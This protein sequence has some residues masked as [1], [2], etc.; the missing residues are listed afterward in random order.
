M[1]GTPTEVEDLTGSDKGGATDAQV[2]PGTHT[3]DETRKRKDSDRKKKGWSEVAGTKLIEPES[4][5]SVSTVMPNRTSPRKSS[6]EKS[7]GTGAATGDVNWS[8]SDDV[9]MVL[10]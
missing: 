8:S 4:S 3:T 2:T 9:R 1:S 6:P 5:T 10:V 7:H